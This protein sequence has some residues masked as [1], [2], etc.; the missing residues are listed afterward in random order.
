MAS[1]AE[2]V[3]LKPR[4]RKAKQA[5][6]DS[7]KTAAMSEQ[8]RKD[9]GTWKDGCVEMLACLPST[10]HKP[11]YALLLAAEH[12]TWTVRARA[13]ER[14]QRTLEVYQRH[15]GGHR[16]NVLGGLAS[17]PEHLAQPAIH[18]TCN[19]EDAGSSAYLGAAA[20]AV[21]DRGGHPLET[22][23]GGAEVLSEAPSP[24]PLSAQAPPPPLDGSHPGASP[25]G[26]SSREWPIPWSPESQ[27]RQSPTALLAALERAPGPGVVGVEVERLARRPTPWSSEEELAR[28]LHVELASVLRKVGVKVEELGTEVEPLEAWQVR[29]RGEPAEEVTRQRL[30]RRRHQLADERRRGKA[31]LAWAKLDLR[32]EWEG[33]PEVAKGALEVAAGRLYRAL[34]PSV[35]Y[36]ER[37]KPL[38][39][40]ACA[41]CGGTGVADP[42]WGAPLV[43]WLKEWRSRWDGRRYGA[44]PWRLLPDWPAFE[45]GDAG[46][47][48]IRA[49]HVH[50]AWKWT[51]AVAIVT[52][53]ALP[54]AASAR[55]ERVM[56]NLNPLELETWRYVTPGQRALE[57]VRAK[58]GEKTWAERELYTRE[59]LPSIAGGVGCRVRHLPSGL[60]AESE[61]QLSFE[62]NRQRAERLLS[63][64][65][66]AMEER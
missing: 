41:G 63:D 57:A 52:A 66:A 64:S 9:V 5:R 40:E 23:T 51:K 11:W 33:L 61:T 50:P 17:L 12:S 62:L 60:E 34:G 43:A 19:A 13:A 16:Y 65:L 22:P 59:V 18:K 53:M 27:A 30:A 42:V 54:A 28:A 15:N 20:Q 7:R 6:K 39:G 26:P 38:A 55:V 3:S 48:E 14:L 8:E 49:F 56:G 47:R 4:K 31:A 29:M 45:T 2:V 36:V 35:V 46:F 24:P 32:P 1:T 58:A 10:Y 21:L 44:S 37:G 25:A